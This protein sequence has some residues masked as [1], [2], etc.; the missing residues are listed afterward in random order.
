[1]A[2]VSALLEKIVGAAPELAH[3]VGPE[4]RTLRDV[5]ADLLGVLEP[6]LLDFVLEELR[7]RPVADPLLP[8][9]RMVHEHVGDQ[10]AREPSRFLFRILHHERIHGAERTR[11][12]LAR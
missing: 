12:S 2:T 10:R 1:M 8:L 6:A 7:Q 4:R 5:G 3:S 9:L 11:E